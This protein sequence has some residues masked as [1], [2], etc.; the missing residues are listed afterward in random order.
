MLV[1]VQTLRKIPR[2]VWVGLAI[3]A[4]FMLAGFFAPLPYSPVQPDPTATLDP[5]SSQHLF[6]TDGSGFDVLSRTISSARRDLPL[7]LAGA[8]AS[9]VVGVPLGLA[10][11]VKGPWGE[12]I[13]R[14]L[15]AFQAFPLL[16]LAIAIVTLTGNRLE[17]VVLAILIINVPR[18]MRLVRS[19]ALSLR[20]S[21]FAEAAI[22]IGATRRRL[23][24]RHLLPNMTGVVL[25]QCS[26]AAAHAIIV[27]AALSFLGIGVNPPEATWGLMIRSG[28]R[29]MSTGQ[30]WTVVFPGLAVFLAVASLNVVADG[31]SDHLEAT[32]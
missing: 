6:G 2:S 15:D 19:E 14:G 27:I 10:A 24:L 4:V 21:R 5:P 8:L 20:E 18:F 22:A 23:M 9:M 16:V 7:A 12:R 29:N 3:V 1:F 26:L 32:D 28:A 30:W 11:S 25:V 17:N 13:M 31:L